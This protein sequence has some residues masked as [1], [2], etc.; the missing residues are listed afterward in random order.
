MKF[1]TLAAA[2]LLCL[3]LS[4]GETLALTKHKSASEFAPGHRQ[5]TPGAAR[6]FAPGHRQTIPGTAE[7]FAPGHLATKK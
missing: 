5:M 1:A 2:V 6:N 7:N 3:T 4:T